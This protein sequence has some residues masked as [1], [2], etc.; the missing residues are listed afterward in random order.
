M[1]Y[2]GGQYFV[3]QKSNS[4]FVNDTCCCEL[5]DFGG[6]NIPVFYHSVDYC[7]PNNNPCQI[8]LRF[9]VRCDAL[10]EP[11]GGSPVGK[12]ILIGNGYCGRVNND[13]WVPH[14]TNPIPPGCYELPANERNIL[15]SA[16][17]CYETCDTEHCLPNPLGE[18]YAVTP[19]PCAK[20]GIDYSTT[21]VPCLA[22]W[23]ARENCNCVTAL[24][25]CRQ[26]MVDPSTTVPNPTVIASAGCT[27]CCELCENYSCDSCNETCRRCQRRSVDEVEEVDGCEYKREPKIMCCDHCNTNVRW[28]QW[29]YFYCPD[30]VIFSGIFTTWW[31]SRCVCGVQTSQYG[32]TGVYDCGGSPCGSLDCSDSF[33]NPPNVGAC[34]NAIGFGDPLS[35]AN[36]GH[37][38]PNDPNP[39]CDNCNNGCRGRGF[40]SVSVGG[41]TISISSVYTL[42]QGNGSG[43]CT[44][45]NTT[46]KI[47]TLDFGAGCAGG[48]DETDNSF[49]G[50]G[51]L[52]PILGFDKGLGIGALL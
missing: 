1:K 29:Q 21:C 27:S 6:Q 10:C 38:Y 11:G 48:C 43:G 23:Q 51:R 13:C 15:N 19:C 14:G 2:S 47:G 5:C 30:T 40:Y 4:V 37:N 31:A 33:T 3:L 24:S 52:S 16:G 45:Y 26:G 36:C 9:Y 34:T 25:G 46:I 32:T 17:G 41:C 12:Y 50:N 20:S 35:P 28:D 49:I 39:T 22:Y 42:Y 18:C 44:P 7:R 8:P